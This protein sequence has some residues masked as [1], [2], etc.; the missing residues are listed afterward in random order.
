MA[1]FL[2][3]DESGFKQHIIDYSHSESRDRAVDVV[4]KRLAVDIC[5]LQGTLT[6]AYQ[7]PI[8]ELRWGLG[9][10]KVGLPA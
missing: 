6:Q 8:R 1:K 7:Q 9:Q 10:F 3:T 2:L 4:T 5:F